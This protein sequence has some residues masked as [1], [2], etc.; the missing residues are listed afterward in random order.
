M[1]NVQ[2]SLAH[3]WQVF[4]H[5]RGEK[6]T[7]RAWRG[8]AEPERP[9]YSIMCPTPPR[10]EQEESRLTNL[11]RDITSRTDL[12]VP[13]LITVSGQDVG[14]QAAVDLVLSKEARMAVVASELGLKLDL[15]GL[16]VLV[17]SLCRGEGGEGG[18]VDL[19]KRE[20]R[21]VE[22]CRTGGGGYS[23]S[24]DRGGEGREEKSLCQIVNTHLLPLAYLHQPALLVV[25][26]GA[27]IP[28]EELEY[29][30]HQLRTLAAGRLI[31]IQ[32][33]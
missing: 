24:S 11:V 21:A 8:P 5:M 15:A 6:P 18:K 13:A 4:S 22:I 26:V 10:G 2:I 16:E 31:L 33:K 20:G 23:F 1:R 9:P 12:S 27:G 25:A 30:L 29:S 28:A 3:H 14:D 19:G 32:N 7:F 17:V